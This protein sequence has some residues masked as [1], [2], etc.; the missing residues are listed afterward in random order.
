MEMY[1]FLLN[2][3][4]IPPK[5]SLKSSDSIEIPLFDDSFE[6]FEALQ[7]NGDNYALFYQMK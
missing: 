7:L 3:N 6:Y 2:L 4:A 1:Q 5:I